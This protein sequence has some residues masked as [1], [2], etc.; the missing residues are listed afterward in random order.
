MKASCDPV[1]TLHE[2]P[3]E[4]EVVSH[5]LMLRAGLVRKLAGGVYSYLPMA[6]R[7]LRK[8]EAI[9]R[10]EMNSAG[11]QEVLLPALQPSDL[12]EKTGRWQAYGPELFRLHDRHERAFALGPT[13]E[14]VITDLVSQVIRSYRQLPF[15]AYQIQTKFRDERRPRFGILRGR[16]FIM[17][18]AYSFSVS[19]ENARQIYTRMQ[20][21]YGRIFLRLG[22]D[23]RMVEAD[24]GLI[25]GN[26]SHEFMVMA[27]SGEDTVVT[28]EKCSWA[29]N[30]EKA[31]DA[32]VCPVCGSVLES[33]T[34]I[35]VGHVFYLGHKYSTPMETTFL[36]SAGKEVPF[37][38]GC[39]G[40]G[41]SRILAATIEQSHD[42]KGI[43]WPVAMA[44]YRTAVLPLGPGM[45]ERREVL[46][47]LESL[48]SLWPGE[49]YFDDR[50]IR[51]GMKFQD[52]DLRGFPFQVILGDRHV[53]KGD[54]EVKIRRTG[55]RLVLPLK[56]IPALLSARV[57]G[58]LSES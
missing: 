24:S 47:L 11:G 25:G 40:I 33:R 10:E 1:Q 45:S 42:D 4:A 43:I 15:I 7:A 9:I 13:H 36:D 16:E 28:C 32:R 37:F 8:V 20:E 57:Q 54:G 30:I 18:D 38:M 3:A 48:E 5:R 23:H 39:Y 56:D 27:D 19:E 46:S 26:L 49:S 52:A 2:E 35:E 44:P 22:L 31:P 41:V 34:A 55:E 51:P 12:W 29:S 53:D 14:E 6:V 17:K 58:I 50:E 21:A